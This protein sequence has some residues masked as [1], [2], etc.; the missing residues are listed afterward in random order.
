MSIE[1]ILWESPER[2]KV[3][4]LLSNS[5]SVPVPYLI[6]LICKNENKSTSQEYHEV[7]E[8]MWVSSIVIAREFS[9]NFFFNFQHSSE[10][11]FGLLSDN[12]IHLSSVT[13]L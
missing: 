12:K 5:D 10:D 7:S 11:G 8:K 1:N 13:F 6:L 4:N 9:K 2:T 3:E